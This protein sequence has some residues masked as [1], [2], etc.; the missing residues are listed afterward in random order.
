MVLTATCMNGLSIFDK[1]YF[2]VHFTAKMRI[3]SVLHII[4]IKLNPIKFHLFDL[5]I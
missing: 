4:K 2:Q 3:R 1:I 5:I